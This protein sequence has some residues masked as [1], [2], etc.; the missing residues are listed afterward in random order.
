LAQKSGFLPH[1]PWLLAKYEPGS[2][3][4]LGTEV[5]ISADDAMRTNV[6]RY[7]S[8]TNNSLAMIG[9]A[10]CRGCTQLRPVTVAA[11]FSSSK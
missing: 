6:Q 10:H 3:G 1:A 2:L 5:V 9:H 4:E 7:F 8:E 11:S